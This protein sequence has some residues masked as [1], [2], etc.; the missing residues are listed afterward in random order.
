MC[1]FVVFS[2]VFDLLF[3]F[4]LTL[5]LF[6]LLQFTQYL[7]IRAVELE[8]VQSTSTQQRYTCSRWIALWPTFISKC[9]SDWCCFQHF[10]MIFKLFGF[11]IPLAD[12]VKPGHSR[13][14]CMSTSDYWLGTTDFCRKILQI[15]VNSR[16]WTISM[17]RNI[18]SVA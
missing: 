6:K 11:C 17:G 14:N 3:L 15:E 12:H 9:S 8:S 5:W 1:S 4:V 16:N 7:L 10:L 2:V 18:N 13:L